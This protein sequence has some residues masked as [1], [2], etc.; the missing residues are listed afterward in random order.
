MTKSTPA[1]PTP[2]KFAKT[3]TSDRPSKNA[4]YELDQQDSRDPGPSRKHAKRAVIEDD[5]SSSSSRS[6]DGLVFSPSKP[7]SKVSKRSETKSKGKQR[8]EESETEDEPEPPRPKSKVSNKASKAKANGKRVHDSE[9]SE[10]S[11]AVVV[12]VSTQKMPSKR[13]KAI[14]SIVE[15]LSDDELSIQAS[16]VK[17]IP[18]GKG[19]R[20]V[21]ARDEDDEEENIPVD[22]T[23]PGPS[24]KNTA[25]REETSC[26]VFARTNG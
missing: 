16:R 15:E 23:L 11:D 24:R 6:D 17:P 10:D 13:P 19:A 3:P 25:T 26:G 2:V 21:S 5:L 1:K 12:P 14:P 7:A 18:R 20:K 9:E 22:N 4:A 8:L